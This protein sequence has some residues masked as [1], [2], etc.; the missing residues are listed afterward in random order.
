MNSSDIFGKK[1]KWALYIFIIG[2]HGMN[3][4]F[5]EFKISV[6]SEQKSF[7]NVI[8]QFLLVK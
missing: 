7:K 2:S 3:R 4:P 5:R 6:I 1:D 8:F